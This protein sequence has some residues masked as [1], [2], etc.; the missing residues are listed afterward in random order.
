MLRVAGVHHVLTMDLHSSQIQGFFQVP[1]D[2]L[3]AEPCIAKYIRDRFHEQMHQLTIISKN[4]GG[5]KR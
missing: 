4:A 2:N 1:V 5:A 3:V